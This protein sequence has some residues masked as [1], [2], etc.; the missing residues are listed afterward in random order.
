MMC[1]ITEC[2]KPRRSRGLCA[3]HA[4]RLRRTGTTNRSTPEYRTGC[5]VEGC[6]RP[7]RTGGLCTLHAS[8]LRRTGDP[9]VVKKARRNSA[10]PDGFDIGNGYR[11]VFVDGRKVKLHRHVMQQ[12]LGRE[13]LPFESVHH[14][15]GIRHDNRIENLE[16]WTAAPVRGVRPEDLVDFVI[17]HYGDIVRERFC[18]NNGWRP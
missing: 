17:E 9:L 15:N 13:L 6:D 8:R 11:G 12:F 3:M 4:A 16:L 14:K 7:H 1:T 2:D 18:G 10:G 5:S